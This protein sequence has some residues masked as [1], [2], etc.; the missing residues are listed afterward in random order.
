[1]SE[2]RVSSPG[3]LIR[4]V[5][6]VRPEIPNVQR[7][8]PPLRLIDNSAPLLRC[9]DPQH[10]EAMQLQR[11]SGEVRPDFLVLQEVFGWI[12]L[13]FYVQKQRPEAKRAAAAVA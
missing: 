13:G 12:W 3:E 1:M 5:V 11:A 6:A 8:A 9:S 7:D 2:V 10:N 4:D